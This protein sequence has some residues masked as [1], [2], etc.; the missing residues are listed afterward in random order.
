MNDH[1]LLQVLQYCVMRQEGDHKSIAIS[2]TERA[3]FLTYRLEGNL[4]ER[5]S[6]P[7]Q[8]TKSVHLNHV[9]QAVLYKV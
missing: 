5:A 2:L 4:L 1:Y 9:L 6:V 8:Y 7:S 3:F